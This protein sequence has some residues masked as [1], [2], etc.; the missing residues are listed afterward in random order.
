M[1]RDRIEF[2]VRVR[3]VTMKCPFL[4]EREPIQ[5]DN[6]FE[7]RFE[8]LKADT[9]VVFELVYRPLFL[10]DRERTRAPVP[11]CLE[12]LPGYENN[13]FRFNQTLMETVGR[14]R[15]FAARERGQASL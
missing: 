3:Y 15:G 10:P 5:T 2:A 6:L 1:D 13:V 9:L 7:F 4:R 11:A 12:T 8:D 14:R